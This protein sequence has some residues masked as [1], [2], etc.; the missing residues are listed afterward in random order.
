MRPVEPVRLDNAWVRLE[1]L[2]PSQADDLV[3]AGSDPGLW[4]FMFGGPLS[5]AGAAQAWIDD[6]LADSALAVTYSV[7]EKESGELA[8]STSLINANTRFRT[9][10]I[11]YTWYA[12]RFQRTVVNTATKRLL[13]GHLFDGP[14]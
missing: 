8:G 4:R 14:L 1:P 9:I 11:G 2:A 5:D 10:E 12:S 6:M 13:L 3:R 7:Y